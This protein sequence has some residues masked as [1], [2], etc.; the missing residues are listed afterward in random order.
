MTFFVEADGIDDLLKEVHAAIIKDGSKIKASKGDTIEI[1]GASLVLTDPIKRVSR[2][3]S[4]SKIISCLGEFL[5]YLTGDNKLSF[6]ERYISVYKEFAEDDGT[7]RG[8][9]GPRIF[10][11]H[12]V[13]NQLENIIT[14]LSHKKT[15]RR[16]LVQ[17]FDASDLA[18]KSNDSKEYKD[19]PC[20]ISL[21]FLI[22][23]DKLNLFVNMRSNDAFKGL[24]HDIFAFTMIQEFISKILNCGLG[25]YYH[26][27][28]SMHLY[29]CDLPKVYAL[30]R[31]GFM[32]TASIMGEMPAINSLD[33]RFQILKV[34]ESLR[35]D[36]LFNIDNS[37]LN[38]YWK[39]LMRLIKINYLFRGDDSLQE[40]HNEMK[41]LKNDSLRIFFEG[42]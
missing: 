37:E 17:L 13:H 38:D 33:L 4:R 20:T 15:S 10:N 16:A 35:S 34:E 29:E 3:E 31:E 11:M 36:K 12:N 41:K 42:K 2:T 14:Q 24:T 19:I 26:Y 8:G 1:L 25:Q 7:I 9:Y 21:Q 40:A 22:R 27:V 28:S 39:D 18:L 6:I 30:Q 32:N 5:W 23:D